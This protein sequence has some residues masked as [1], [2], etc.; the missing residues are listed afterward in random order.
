MTIK[1]PLRYPGGKSRAVKHILPLIPGDARVILSPFLGGGSL[2][3]AL[4]GRGHKVQA[5]EI[6]FPL[7]CFWNVVMGEAGSRIKM[8][9]M[10]RSEHPLK[11]DRFY[12]IQ[13]DLRIYTSKDRKHDKDVSWYAAMFFVLNRSSYSGTTL[14]GGMSPEHPR[15]TLSSIERL[16][17]FSPPIR[18]GIKNRDGM[19]RIGKSGRFDFIYADPPYLVESNLY[20]NK[21]STHKGFDHERLASLLHREGADWLL[22]YN[23]CPR[24]RSLY[25][26]CEFIPAAWAYGMNR[27]RRSN[28]VLIRPR[29]N[30]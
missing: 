9:D 13:E 28:E 8:F 26:G 19:S 1:S 5:Y 25:D 24:V 20:G 14:S 10:V 21:G 11:K 16:E 29:R 4:A 3:I 27:S 15:F 17:K 12:Q 22:S 23:D 6:F 2:E 30:R 18:L 7:Y